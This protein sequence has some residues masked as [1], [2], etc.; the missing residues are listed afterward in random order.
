VKN[1]AI[2][3]YIFAF[4]VNW[5]ILASY[6]WYFSSHGIDVAH[7]SGILGDD[8]KIAVL[9]TPAHLSHPSLADPRIKEKYCAAALKETKN[10]SMHG[11]MVA[12]I[13]GAKAHD[14][15]PDFIGV[16]PKAIVATFGVPEKECGLKILEEALLKI[17]EFKPDIINVSSTVI[18]LSDARIVQILEEMVKE[19]PSLIIVVAAGNDGAVLEHAGIPCKDLSELEASAQVELEHLATHKLK[20]NFVMVGN[21]ARAREVDF[22]DLLLIPDKD[23]QRMNK[24][25]NFMG[26]TYSLARRIPANKAADIVRN[27][28]KSIGESAD[29]FSKFDAFHTYLL[30]DKFNRSSEDE[31]LFYGGKYNPAGD[32]PSD[33][34]I[35]F[36][37]MMD[38]KIGNFEGDQQKISRLIEVKTAA[39]DIKRTL[40]VKELKSELCRKEMTKEIANI[41]F[42]NNGQ[43]KAMN[44]LFI[45]GL[46]KNNSR[47]LK[48]AKDF[49]PISFDQIKFD[50]D[51]VLNPSSARAGA[52]SD[53]F[54]SA[55]GTNIPT[56]SLEFDEADKNK[57]R[58]LYKIVN[59]TGTSMAAPIVS[60]AI[61]LVAQ[62]CKVTPRQAL[63]E[64]YH[65]ADKAGNFWVF[66]K[67]KINI[68]KIIER[69]IL[70]R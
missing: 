13:I 56:A 35:R 61:A 2:V 19:N 63:S 12:S 7:N 26:R 8:L 29:Y 69:C 27:Y 54:I 65:Q 25:P 62:A 67:G 10:I 48:L 39:R 5:P 3:I 30:T 42:V 32:I 45:D 11:T 52:L 58:P 46:P 9:D 18:S 4:L 21:L 20:E 36:T 44:D 68:R 37:V 6:P 70:E 53:I 14:A 47:L 15:Y 23:P 66:G 16:A 57:E 59:S 34:N 51:L 43:F 55:F 1:N 49:I 50:P 28:L 38:S 17:K 31:I 40:L 22:G 33:A 60:G 41:K 64:I 24:D